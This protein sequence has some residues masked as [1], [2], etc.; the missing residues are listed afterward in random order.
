M[1]AQAIREVVDRIG[2]N[3]VILLAGWGMIAATYFILR[4]PVM[5]GSFEATIKRY[6]LLGSGV[7]LLLTFA[8][9]LTWNWF[10]WPK[11]LGYFNSVAPDDP[12]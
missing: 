3:G 6:L 12:S 7:L 1:A 4:I 8:T 11:R 10:G 2:A 9:F 5:D